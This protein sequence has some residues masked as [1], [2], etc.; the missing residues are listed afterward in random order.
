M[1]FMVPRGST[2]IIRN[3]G[4]PSEAETTILDLLRQHLKSDK[5]WK[6]LMQ[7]E[8]VYTSYINDRIALQRKI[9]SIL[10]EKTG[11]ELIDKAAVPPPFLYSYTTGCTLY[12]AILRKI[13]ISN[14]KSFLVEDDVIAD[15][16]AGTVKYHGLILAEAHGNETKCRDD[17]IATYKE[18]LGS[19]E[20][21]SIKVTCEQLKEWAAKAR[22]AT[23]EILLLGYI[24]GQCSVC[25][26]LGM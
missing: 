22:Q 26:R 19:S 7:W 16:E 6:L 2:G 20:L 1:S 8:A 12:E 14:G 15:T 24:P 25:R 18:V 11:Y 13:L 21:N 4:R 17:I 3:V 23:D 9:V 5:L 10:K